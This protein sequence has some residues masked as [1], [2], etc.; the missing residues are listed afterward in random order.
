MTTLQKYEEQSFDIESKRDLIKSVFFKGCSNDEVEL[1]LHVCKKT[2]LDP[3][4]KQIYPVK[5]WS[6]AEKKE[7][8][9]C[10]TS[11][12]GFRLIAERTGRYSPGRESTYT[13]DKDG[14]L[15]SATSYVKKMTSDG[16]WHEVAATAF[17]DEYAQKNKEGKLTQFWERMQHVML[18]KCAEALALR[19]AFPA[20]LSGI[21]TS[22]EMGQAHN[23]VKA[24]PVVEQ[25]ALIT[26]QQADEIESLLKGRDSL[27]SK[28]LSWAEIES[29]SELAASK[30][31]GVMKAIENHIAKEGS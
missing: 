29:V 5:R 24:H 22:D 14:N 6:S 20:D 27:K 18:A 26:P 25:P 13:Y 17:F 1:F 28:L 2:G 10:Q 30:H 7:V 3:M 16:T 4:M 9:T 11:I 31:A 23:E 19:K 8:M 15:M 12:D 21:Y